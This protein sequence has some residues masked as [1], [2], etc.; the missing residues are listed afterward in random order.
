MP[1]RKLNLQKEQEEI[2]EIGQEFKDYGEPARR[3]Y[4][5]E[6]EEFNRIFRELKK[7]RKKWKNLKSPWEEEE[8]KE[9]A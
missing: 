5:E 3:L 8:E 1:F 7:Q 6:P 2:S 9:T 4:R